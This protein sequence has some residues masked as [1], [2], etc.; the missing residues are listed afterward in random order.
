[1][2]RP[3]SANQNLASN[4]T[5]VLASLR[6][7][8]FKHSIWNYLISIEVIFSADPFHSLSKKADLA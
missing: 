6:N 2:L 8:T 5:A 1:M 3:M 4:L 7:V